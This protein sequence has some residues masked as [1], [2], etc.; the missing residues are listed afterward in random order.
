[1]PFGLTNTPMIYQRMIDNAP[2]G[3]VQPKGGWRAFADR[4]QA[5]EERAD[6][7]RQL[8]N[9]ASMHWSA[10]PQNVRT[11]FD[12]AH[13]DS[14]TA[15]PVSQLII[16]P[17]ADLF[18]TSEADTSTLVPVFDRRSFVD[19]VCFG[20]KT[21]D[22]CMAT[23]D[24]LLSRFE[25]CRISISFTKSILHSHES[26]SCPTISHGTVCVPIHRS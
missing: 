5:A 12:A 20:G 15:D 18:T 14:V 23:L 10:T 11:K 6:K 1:M 16:S 8:R 4:M 13:E 26:I 7:S 17:D 19:D 24:K 21:F 9:E 22:E 3:F 2:W 25:E